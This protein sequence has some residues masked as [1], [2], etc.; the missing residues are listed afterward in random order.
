MAGRRSYKCACACACER[1]RQTLSVW[2]REHARMW[3]PLPYI[4]S[5]GADGGGGGGFHIIHYRCPLH[6]A[7]VTTAPSEG[8][9]NCDGDCDCDSFFMV[10]SVSE[11]VCVC[12]G[13]SFVIATGGPRPKA[14][15]GCPLL[16][17]FFLGVLPECWCVFFFG[18]WSGCF[19]CVC[20]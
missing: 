6:R 14:R 17:F 4:G 1:G 20:V 2:E 5:A 8:G 16:A 11:C 13:I 12:A 19:L 9:P 18:R 3:L 15:K 7:A 10:C